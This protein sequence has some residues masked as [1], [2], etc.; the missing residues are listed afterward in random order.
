MKTAVK[1]KKIIKNVGSGTSLTNKSIQLSGTAVF[2]KLIFY[3]TLWN[4]FLFEANSGVK[5]C[6]LKVLLEYLRQFPCKVEGCSYLND[7]MYFF[8][9]YF[10]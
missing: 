2:F 8:S 5:C 9:L 10:M 6:N 4:I 7:N 3:K 1:T